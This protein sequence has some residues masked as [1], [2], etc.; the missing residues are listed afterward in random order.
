MGFATKKKKK[1]RQP[2]KRTLDA[3]L[4]RDITRQEMYQKRNFKFKSFAECLSKDVPKILLKL[5]AQV[6]FQSIYRTQRISFTGFF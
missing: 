5:W 4:A 1:E 3:N 2:N 6:F